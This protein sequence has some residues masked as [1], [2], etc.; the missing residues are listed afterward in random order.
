MRA[1]EQKGRP[2]GYVPHEYTRPNGTPYLAKVKGVKQKLRAS[3]HGIWGPGGNSYPKP[4]SATDGRDG[5]VNA[6]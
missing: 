6:S 1:H 3:A 5:W 4:I 2:P